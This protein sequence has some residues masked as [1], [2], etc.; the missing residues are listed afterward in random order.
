MQIS[1]RTDLR[2]RCCCP[3]KPS[4]PTRALRDSLTEQLG[5]LIAVRQEQLLTPTCCRNGRPE[6]RIGNGWVTARI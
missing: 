1:W 2:A 6:I 3:S 5:N 4:K